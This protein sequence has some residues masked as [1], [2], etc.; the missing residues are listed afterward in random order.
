MDDDLR[1]G[2]VGLVG[3]GAV[4]AGDV[5]HPADGQQLR[6]L[7]SL[8]REAR[9]RLVPAPVAAGVDGVIS[10]AADRLDAVRVD[11]PAVLMHAGAAA[12]WSDARQAAA[13]SGLAISGLGP[14]RGDT[15]GASVGAGEVSHR[16]VAGVDLL[17]GAG[18]LISA[19][20]R[21]LKDVVGYD[22][23]GLAL[24]SGDKLG[25]IV[26]VTLRLEPQAA[27]TAAVAGSGP[28]R[29]DAGL[30]VATAFNP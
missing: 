29:G 11:A 21:T 30:D 2:I 22:L 1:R 16:T 25:L 5:V 24:G 8:C 14:L 20:G 26:G 10:V 13:A 6:E 23:A 15:V 7:V 28:W 19:A 4:D 12:T 18:E 17:T 3:N 27:R 9:R